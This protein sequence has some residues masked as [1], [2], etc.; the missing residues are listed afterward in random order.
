MISGI[1]FFLFFEKAGDTDEMMQHTMQAPGSVQWSV[2]DPR[3]G[4]MMEYPPAVSQ[5]LE[6]AFQAGKDK[7][8][9]FHHPSDW[10]VVC[11]E[12]NSCIGTE[13]VWLSR[14]QEDICIATVQGPKG[15]AGVW[16]CSVL[17][18]CG[19]GSIST[20]NAAAVVIASCS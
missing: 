11:L 6:A 17:L 2:M 4:D 15:L 5:Q 1:V 13:R 7:V 9:S 18:A 10:L 12:G 19:H 16:S 3:S 14:I 8:A 20:C